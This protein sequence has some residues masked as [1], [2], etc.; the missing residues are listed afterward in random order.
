M[1]NA[2]KSHRRRSTSTRSQT[3][4]ESGSEKRQHQKSTP[5]RQ[6]ESGSCGCEM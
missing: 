5:S 6:E 1:R 2:I 4:R 3:S